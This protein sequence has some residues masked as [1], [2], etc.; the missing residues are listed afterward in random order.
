MPELPEVQTIVSAYRERLEGRRIARFTS[1]WP[2]NCLPDAAAVAAAGQGRTIRA[3]GRRG[4][5]IV[6]EL[7]PRGALLVHLRMSGRFEWSAADAPEPRH[8]RAVLDFDD[9]HRLWFCDARKFGRIRYVEDPA[10]ATAE[11]GLEPLEPSFTTAALAARLAGRARQIKPLLLDQTVIAGLGNIY[12]DEALFRAGI[13]PLARAADV[14]P[15]QV[16]SLRKAIRDVLSQAIAREGTS[17]DWSYPGGRMQSALRVYGRAGKPCRRCGAEI[18]AMRVAQRGTHYC[19][20][21]QPAPRA[22]RRRSG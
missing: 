21:C 1:R 10:Q 14:S 3:V 4:K 6:L 2:R 19:P 7:S 11:L 22:A 13:Y 18:Q 5:W 8:V 9:G 17:I 16:R 20:V 15:A 12:T